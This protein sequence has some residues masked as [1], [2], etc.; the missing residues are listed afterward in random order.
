M[1][2]TKPERIKKLTS[3]AMEAY[4]ETIK[5][6]EEKIKEHWENLDKFISD[7]GTL[8]QDVDSLQ[9][10]SVKSK[11]IQYYS[12]F[13]SKATEFLRYLSRTGTE[14]S[15]SKYSLVTADI[16]DKRKAANAFM[17]FLKGLKSDLF[18]KSSKTSKSSRARLN[19]AKAKVAYAE[20]AAELELQRV[21]LEEKEKKE[22]AESTRRKQELDIEMQLLK[23]KEELDLAI[24]ELEQLSDSDADLES[25]LNDIPIADSKIRTAEFISKVKQEKSL[26]PEAVSFQPSSTGND[27]TKYLLKKDLLI[28]RMTVFNEKPETYQSWK[29]TFKSVMKE[30]DANPSEET[31]LLIKWLGSSSKSQATSLKAAF[32][33]NP[34]EGLRKI[35]ERLDERFGTPE[36][37]YHATMTKLSSF[38]KISARTSSQL[39]D[40]SDILSEIEGL[41]CDPKYS[42]ILSYFDAAIGVNLIVNKLPQFLQEKWTTTA[43]RY[44]QSFNVAFPPFSEFAKF[45]REQSRIRNDPSFNFDAP[46]SVAT[47]TPKH[48]RSSYDRH[49]SVRKTTVIDDKCPIHRTSHKLEKCRV[50]KGMSQDEKKKFLFEK[51]LCFKCYS[52]QHRASECHMN[53]SAPAPSFNNKPYSY[54][55]DHK[56]K[57]AQDPQRKNVTVTT[58]CTEICDSSEGKSCSKIVLV[59]VFSQNNN[60]NVVKCYCIVDEQSNRSLIKPELFSMLG[61]CGQNHEYLLKKCNGCMVVS[62]RRASNIV[63]QSLD[64]SCTYNLPTL[65]EW[66]SYT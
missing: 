20:K 42:S 57:E 2:S 33:Y 35:W 6:Y 13:D 12:V 29:Q 17:D 1:T 22:A 31:D 5:R 30:I 21:A 37:V 32:I 8:T 47:A 25:K 54:A 58:S 52:S 46:L 3:K 10:K 16:A 59:N 9:L 40:L 27:F 38:P 51:H 14:D 28:S 36:N 18:S 49:V 26:N 66:F 56:T 4:A 62:G 7:N 65:I 53:E 15:L 61:I 55:D 63:V 23:D 41:K 50:F 11:T 44:K 34:T 24:V 48:T 43:T 39:Y 60:E 64:G 19:A 45:V